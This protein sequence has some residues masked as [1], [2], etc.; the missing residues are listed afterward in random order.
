MKKPIPQ[1]DLH[2]PGEVFTLAGQST[3]DGER[4]RR[5][6]EAA[7]RD[8]AAAAQ[9]PDLLGE[10]DPDDPPEWRGDETW[11]SGNALRDGTPTC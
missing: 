2:L 6:S 4:L 10:P 5:E 1:F 8:R 11:Q 9:Q 7:A 3:L